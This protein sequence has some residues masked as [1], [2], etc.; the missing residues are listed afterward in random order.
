MVRNRALAKGHGKRLHEGSVSSL[1]DGQDDAVVLRRWLSI[2][3]RNVGV[4][5]GIAMFVG[6]GGVM[7]SRCVELLKEMMDSM[8]S[9]RDEEEQKRGGGA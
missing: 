4:A 8:G 7:I 6:V 2:L 1:R 9:R 3:P 5:L